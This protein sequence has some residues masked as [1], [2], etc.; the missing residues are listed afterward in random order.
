MV[1]FRKLFQTERYPSNGVGGQDVGLTTTDSHSD[2]QSRPSPSPQFPVK[3]ARPADG[4]MDV[5]RHFQRIE[6]Q[7]EEL[8][9]SMQARPTPQ[10]AQIPSRTSSRFAIR[11]PRHVDLFDA[12]FSS[13]QRHQAQQSPKNHH[14]QHQQHHLPPNNPNNKSPSSASP[15]SPYNEDVAERNMA[16]SPQKPPRKRSL[17]SRFISA[18]H[19]DDAAVKNMPKGKDGARP[20]SRSANKSPISPNADN[21]AKAKENRPPTGLVP[22]EAATRPRSRGVN[23][24]VTSIPRETQPRPHLRSQRSAPNLSTAKLSPSPQKGPERSPDPGPVGHLS[25]P[26]AHKQGDAWSSTPLPDSPTLPGQPTATGKHDRSEPSAPV[27]KAH[28]T[29]VH[30]N[31]SKPPSSKAPSR[32]VPSRK[33]TLNL[34]INTQVAALGSQPA[35]PSPRAIQPPTPNS[36][37]DTKYNPSIAEVMN[38]P[39]PSA[40]PTSVSPVPSSNQKVAEIMD[41]FKQAYN[42]TPARPISPHPTF[43]TL[44]DAIVREINSHEAFR[45]LP[46][47]EP[48][49]A[50]TPS[51]AR[52]SFDRRDSTA[53]SAKNSSTSVSRNS[54]GKENQLSKLIKPSPFKKH[55]RNSETRSS[56][57]TSV[58]PAVLGRV[59]M[60]GNRRRH[61]DAPPP[62]PGFFDEPTSQEKDKDE[63]MPLSPSYE[64]PPSRS[65][66]V[67]PGAT[68]S[69]IAKKRSISLSK[70]HAPSQSVVTLASPASSTATAAA[71]AGPRSVYYMRAQTSPISSDGKTSFSVGDSSDDFSEEDVLHLPSP[72]QTSS[73]PQQSHKT[74]NSL[75]SAN[76][77]TPATAKSRWSIFPPKPNATTVSV[78]SLSSSSV[79]L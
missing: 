8:H 73:T 13:S 69:T 64:E 14:Q 65:Q 61:T 3:S 10:V 77:T 34:S 45:R 22:R 59:S 24:P 41:M 21:G 36:N 70:T 66:T 32:P 71:A 23:E 12:A 26:P 4:S 62:S 48:G 11:N 27:T 56:I 79:Q 18:I 78:A 5:D 9:D 52:E 55:R 68:S 2:V 54:S 1:T 40:T 76:A 38:S 51:P 16:Q 53:K 29:L 33:N 35:K 6:R 50:F 46:V 63:P 75:V 47:P 74:K 19:Q 7:L 57:S 67:P 20:R 25:V 17:Y 72:S 15:V 49:P 39:L 43:E 28:S 42:S 44:Q 58:V 60:S 30:A 37:N 31:P